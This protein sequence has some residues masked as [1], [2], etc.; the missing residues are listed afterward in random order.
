MKKLLEHHIQ[1]QII[2]WSKYKQ[3]IGPYLIHIPNGGYRKP[4]EAA[5]FKRMGVLAG[6]SDLFLAKPSKRA[7]GLWME[8][9]RPGNKLTKAQEEWFS[10]M[11]NQGYEAKTVHSLDD[12]SR[13]I[14][15]YLYNN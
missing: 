11:L 10:L 2:E 4:S 9:K 7:H 15:K 3:D 8:L 1:A 14:Q 6:V 13:I 12:A 5:K